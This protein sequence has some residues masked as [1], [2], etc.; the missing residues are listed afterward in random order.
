[1]DPGGLYPAHADPG[2]AH[3]EV[4]TVN[5]QKMRSLLGAHFCTHNISQN[6]D[7]MHEKMIIN[8]K[9]LRNLTY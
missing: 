4:N 2:L 9:Q 6:I 7:I 8:Q 5:D 1:L 3:D